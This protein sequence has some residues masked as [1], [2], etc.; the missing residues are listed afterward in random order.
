M[1]WGGATVDTSRGEQLEASHGPRD[2]DFCL[3][4]FGGCG[5]VPTPSTPHARLESGG[6]AVIDSLHVRRVIFF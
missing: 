4:D 2:R 1:R 5:F 6:G 3:S